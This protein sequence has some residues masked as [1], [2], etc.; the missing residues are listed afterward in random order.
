LE[1]SDDDDDFAE[2]AF[3][4]LM[5]IGQILSIVLSTARTEDG[6]PGRLERN[7]A[8]VGGLLVRCYKLLH[9]LLD[10]AS[11]QRLELVMYFVRGIAEAGVNARYL[12]AK[13]DSETYDDFVRYSLRTDLELRE[14]IDANIAAR[15]GEVLPIEERMLAGIENSFRLGEISPESIDL[16]VRRQKWSQDSIYGR[17][18]VLGLGDLYLAFFGVPS[19][20]SHG[21][22]HELYAHHLRHYDDGFE[23]APDWSPTRP[24]PLA[25]TGV[26]LLGATR[27]YLDTFPDNPDR[28]KIEGWLDERDRDLREVEELH[29]ASLVRRRKVG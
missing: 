8:I 21:N 24:Q 13:D 2:A 18:T 6:S 29:E 3:H 25:A 20:Y 26:M 7:E 4:V 5:D 17:F 11:K 19:G 27:D 12:L 10:A 22:W 15:D 23:L 28:R 16:A 9:G 1:R 14:K